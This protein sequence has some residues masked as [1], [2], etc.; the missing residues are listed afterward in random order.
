[1]PEAHMQAEPALVPF[2]HVAAAPTVALPIVAPPIVAPRTAAA[3]IAEPMCAV[4]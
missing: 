1:M 3:R 4:A 2:T